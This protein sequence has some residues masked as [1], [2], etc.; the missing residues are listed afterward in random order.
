MGR[1]ARDSSTHLP[2]QTRETPGSPAV[3]PPP[4]PLVPQR[5][6][7]SV[8]ERRQRVG[9]RAAPGRGAARLKH[10][11][12]DGRQA[13]AFAPVPTP[14]GPLPRKERSYFTWH[15]EYSA[16]GCDDGQVAPAPDA[17]RVQALVTVVLR[18]WSLQQTRDAGVAAGVAAGAPLR[19]AGALRLLGDHRHRARVAA[20]AGPPT[21]V[22]SL[23]P[24]VE[25]AALAASARTRWCSPRCWRCS[26]RTWPTSRR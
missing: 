26:G 1:A 6:R 10:L 2:G 21:V 23:A 4:A 13:P 19:D 5:V 9:R 25:Q 11:C 18:P 8:L 17:E 12:I 3:L 16:R 20:G 15:W 24:Q 14:R 7:A 22:L